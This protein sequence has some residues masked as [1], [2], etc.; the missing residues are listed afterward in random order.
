MSE[1]SPQS[2]APARSRR[3]ALTATVVA[4]LVVLPLAL[5]LASTCSSPEAT[6]A[7]GSAEVPA[8]GLA[9]PADASPTDTLSPGT[10]AR[11][12]A[13]S[14]AVAGP[15]AIT[16]RVIGRDG[17][18]IGEVALEVVGPD[19]VVAT[20]ESELDGGFRTGPLPLELYVVRAR[21]EGFADALADDVVPG[22]PAVVLTLHPGRALTLRLDPP[23]PTAVCHL[24]GAGLF[25]PRRVEASEDGAA[26]RFDGLGAGQYQ[27]VATAVGRGS[28]IERFELADARGGAGRLPVLRL[29]TAS[30]LEVDV[31]LGSSDAFV[32]LAGAL[33][34]VS[35]EPLHVLGIHEVTDGLGRVRFEGLREG[36][37][38]VSVRAPGYLPQAPV[39]V[40]LPRNQ[41]L[42]VRPDPGVTVSGRVVDERG[43]AVALADLV[44]QVETPD[45][46]HWVVERDNLDVLN[47]L[48]RR[49]STSLGRPRTSFR[50]AS[51]GTFVLGGLPLGR[52]VVEARKEGW[53]P[54]S[55]PVAVE[56]DAQGSASGLELR[57]TRGAP[58]AGRVVGPGGGGL[59]SATVRWRVPGD[60]VWGWR[61]T[62]RTN[63]RGEFELAGVSS[64]VELEVSAE[65]YATRIVT[66][67]REGDDGSR[68]VQLEPV[69]GRIVGRVMGPSGPVVGAQVRRAA[70]GLDPLSCMGRSGSDGRFGLEGC[71]SEPVVIEVVG[72]SMAPLYAQARAGD[73]LELEA[74]VGGTLSGEAVSASGVAL[75]EATLTLEASLPV[76]GSERRHS[77]VRAHTFGTGGFE[78]SYVP[79]GRYEV[80]IESPSMAPWSGSRTVEVGSRVELGR[81][82]LEALGE[83]EGVV[84][85]ELGGPVSGAR[86][87][88]SG[89]SGGGVGEAVTDGSGRYVLRGVAAGGEVQVQAVHWL[90]GQ[91]SSAARV[92]A[93]EAARVTVRLTEVLDAGRAEQSALLTAE[94]VVFE[95]EERGFVVSQVAESSPW[96]DVGLERGDFVESVEVSG[97]VIRVV[98]V[99]RE[100]KRRRLL[101]R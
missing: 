63:G 41:S 3:L 83:V 100:S 32:G 97:G 35:A 43:A 6:V 99:V 57:L 37:W 73:E 40:R 30:A 67:A 85:D 69:A 54:A 79:A 68:T 15:F 1:T 11:S 50:S 87:W 51:D 5:W 2:T 75:G 16:G 46:A 58:L 61:A 27:V 24:G 59:A 39:A 14:S 38:Y 90:L 65:G 13:T 49:G 48:V 93:G 9:E 4:L 62:A 71:G 55:R 82:T 70:T 45:G 52:V 98:E 101:R 31:G 25:P 92:E 74:T 8:E 96:A 77:F 36:V 47:R 95:R 53:V 81:V 94:G 89:A 88:V 72:P 10:A 34:T 29:A 84:V 17:Q 60:E 18:G 26:C 22:G 91:G 64:Q 86:V 19:G 66:V 76:V 42:V 12:Q 78:L 33:V 21:L 44:A 7:E 20:V 28:R 23:D 56:L 80:R